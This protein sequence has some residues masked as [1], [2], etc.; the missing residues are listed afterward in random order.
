MTKKRSINTK[1]MMS[2]TYNAGVC[3]RQPQIQS[4]EVTKGEVKLV[5]R[6]NIVWLLTLMASPEV[7]RSCSWTDFNILSCDEVTVVE[8]IVGYVPII[9]APAAQ[10]STVNE[11]LNQSINIIQ[12]LELNTIV[13]VF[14]EDFFAKAA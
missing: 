12:S 14:D 7:Q 8:N 10:K 2:P 13:C 9:T 11:M 3:V 1:P 6:E 4:L 5:K